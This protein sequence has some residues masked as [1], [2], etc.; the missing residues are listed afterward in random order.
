MGLKHAADTRE[1]FRQRLRL[2]I[3]V[4]LSPLRLRVKS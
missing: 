3:R 2:S 4:V 1:E